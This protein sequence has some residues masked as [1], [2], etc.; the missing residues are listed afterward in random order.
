M[1]HPSDLFIIEDYWNLLLTWELIFYSVCLTTSSII[2]IY[3]YGETQREREDELWFI[4][5]EMFA[6]ITCQWLIVIDF[7][8]WKKWLLE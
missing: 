8:F 3:P 5:N 1:K 6:N 7:S 2:Y 4:V